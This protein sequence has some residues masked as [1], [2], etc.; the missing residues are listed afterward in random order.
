MEQPQNAAVQQVA[1]MGNNNPLRSPPYFDGKQEKYR[2][3]LSKLTFF[4]C[5]TDLDAEKLGLMIASR[6]GGQALK[7]AMMIPPTELMDDEMVD[8][9]SVGIEKD[10]IPNGV[11]NLLQALDDGG[12]RTQAHLIGVT[13]MNDFM[14]YKQ[15]KDMPMQEYVIEYKTLLNRAVSGGLE[16][17]DKVQAI[18]MM[19]KTNLLE[20]AYHHVLAAAGPPS[21]ETEI[22]IEIEMK[23]K[24]E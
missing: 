22:E 11:H 5:L 18:L 21:T 15:P 19:T 12:Y 24:N 9:R 20:S 8:G 17:T 1:D 13:S 14:S 6:L 4:L 3:W 2:E 7:I 10:E 16:L 23:M